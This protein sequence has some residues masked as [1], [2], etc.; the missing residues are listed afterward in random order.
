MD[1]ILE[2]QFPFFRRNA[3]D[4]FVIPEINHA[5][6]P[7][8]LDFQKCFHHLCVRIGIILWVSVEHDP[9][10]PRFFCIRNDVLDRTADGF[11]IEAVQIT[12]FRNFAERAVARCIVR[13]KLAD[14][15]IHLTLRVEIVAHALDVGILT[16]INQCCSIDRF[17]DADTTVF[18]RYV[19]RERIVVGRKSLRHGRS[20]EDN[21]L[22][23]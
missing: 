19:L 11:D 17:F 23:F 4:P 6:L 10:V 14:K 12:G 2:I 15:Q 3:V 9:A 1:R 18:F 20:Q 22:S 7:F 13:G 5:D 8:F 16:V 21:R